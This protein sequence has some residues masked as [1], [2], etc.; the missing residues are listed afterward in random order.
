MGKIL[1]CAKHRLK[2]KVGMKCLQPIVKQINI[3]K[4]KE[5]HKK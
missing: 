1:H 2:S 5:H 4:W 3:T